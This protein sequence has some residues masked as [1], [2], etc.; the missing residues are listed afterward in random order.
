MGRPLGKTQRQVLKSLNE[1][2]SGMWYTGCGWYWDN[3]SG[4]KRIMES[5]QRRGLVDY[6]PAS[7]EYHSYREERWTIND[8][9]RKEIAK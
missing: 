9:G 6:R 2:N 4:T 5:L 3:W 8:E 7:R 1:H